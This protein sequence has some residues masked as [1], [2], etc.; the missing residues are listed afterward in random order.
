M[1]ISLLIPSILRGLLVEIMIFI[2]FWIQE[3]DYVV[4]LDQGLILRD[5]VSH[6]GG[7]QG[8]GLREVEV[9]AEDLGDFSKSNGLIN[10]WCMNALK[11]LCFT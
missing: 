4:V 3:E 2:R 10:P 7:L 11:R 8:S 9:S 6:A 1:Q 5:L